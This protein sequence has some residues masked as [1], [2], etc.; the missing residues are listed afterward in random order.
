[1]SAGA[2]P[3]VSST[4]GEAWS[5]IH[6]LAMS[7]KGRFVALAHEFDLTPMQMGALRTLDPEAPVPMS[8]LAGALYC[9]ASNV[10][11][12]VDRLEARRLVER[13]G[14][15]HDRRV[16]MLALTEEGARVRE[17]LAAR[18]SEPPPQL[19]A[20]SAADQRALLDILRR[21]LEL[22]RG[23]AGTEPPA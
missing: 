19:A 18:M 15:D 7:Q 22:E 8:E 4:A 1:M 6:Q 5:L 23:S 3:H 16:R 12:I 2:P 20:L 17:I 14:A 11:G 9:E 21:A 10:T 13:R